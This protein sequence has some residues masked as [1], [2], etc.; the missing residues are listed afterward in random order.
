MLKKALIFCC[1]L[2]PISSNAAIIDYGLSTGDTITGLR[3]LDLTE[4][5]NR[6]YNDISSKLG[7]GQ[8]FEGWRYAT[9]AE[10]QTLWEH[11]GL[12]LGL[13]SWI[14]VTS[15]EFPN[16]N[17]A[18]SLLGDTVS[19]QHP[20]YNYGT[21]GIT[22]DGPNEFNRYING[23]S[24]PTVYNQ[25]DSTLVNYANGASLCTAICTDP[26][27]GSWLVKT[28]L[29]AV[30]VPAAGWMFISALLALAGR[31]CLASKG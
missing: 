10:V 17:Y 19:D 26:T 18:V 2:L 31:R 28:E 1:F 25:F 12:T 7:S 23:M 6:S 15:E 21:K 4:T 14:S 16:F 29:T 22:A 11:M 5:V 13:E 30:P 3:W 20:K 24:G 8:E 27:V 9:Q